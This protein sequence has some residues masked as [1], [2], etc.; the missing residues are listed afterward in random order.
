VDEYVRTYCAAGVL[1]GGFELYR[2]VAT[3]TADNSALTAD[4]LTLPILSMGAAR[5]NDPDAE[6][7]QLRQLLQPMAAGPISAE[8]VPSSGHFL[9]EENPGFVVA[10]LRAFIDG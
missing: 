8:L 9:P 3:D 7:A 10:A 5:S 4:R 6:R 2:T 1:H